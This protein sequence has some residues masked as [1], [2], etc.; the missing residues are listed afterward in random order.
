M[1]ADRLIVPGRG[2][3]LPPE[4]VIEKLR[5]TVKELVRK[6]DELVKIA[7]TLARENTILRN[8]A[9]LAEHPNVPLRAQRRAEARAAK[10]AAK[11]GET[12]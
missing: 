6:N 3:A 2:M 1:G 12:K 8:F 5:D 4:V 10:K 9:G 7:N 11:K